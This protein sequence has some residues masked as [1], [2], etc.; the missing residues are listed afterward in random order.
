MRPVPFDYTL[1]DGLDHALALLDEH[2]DDARPLAGGQSL[3]PMMN[4]RLARPE[5]LIDINRLALD[6]ITVDNGT[7][8]VGALVRHSQLLG[9]A[10]VAERAPVIAEA[11]REIAHPTIRNR[12]TIG[13]SVAHADP[14]AELPMLLL[15]L[16]GVVEAR[17]RG[18]TRRIEAAD[19]FRGAFTTALTPGE[20]VTGLEFRLPVGAWGGSFIELA[21][22]R[23]DYAIVAVAAAIAVDGGRIREARLVCAGA[24]SVAVRGGD[25]EQFLAGRALDDNGA[26]EAGRIFA[27]AHDAY[28]D[29]RA[30]AAY[31]RHLIAELTRRAV[32]TAC[33]RV[34]S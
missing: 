5:M 14:T 2:G 3:V 32:D 25:A 9:D 34:A 33:A 1:A 19:F 31:R 21:E 10:A 7:I 6:D 24:E 29:I 20:M 18:G 17:S 30:T 22:R 26:A 4:L 11:V 28:D 15:L 23:G 16:D 13:G 12:G 27:A 8:G